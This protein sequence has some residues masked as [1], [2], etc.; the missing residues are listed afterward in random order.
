MYLFKNNMIIIIVTERKFFGAG[1]AFRVN[2]TYLHDFLSR[3]FNLEL[4]IMKIFSFPIPKFLRPKCS[5]QLVAF[6]NYN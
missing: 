2:L 6:I 5:I 4:I 1:V 3:L